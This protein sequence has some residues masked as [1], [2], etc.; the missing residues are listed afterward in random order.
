MEWGLLLGVLEQGLILLNTPESVKAA[1]EVK[2]LRM[3]YEDEI[4]KP[5]SNQSDLAL[6]RIRRRVRIISK[7]F[8]EFGFASKS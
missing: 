8:V 6:S 3:E 4:S 2:K 5:E 1:K 7:S